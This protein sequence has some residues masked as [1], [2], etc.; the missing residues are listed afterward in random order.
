MGRVL[1][2]DYGQ[3]RVGL[4]VTDP[5]RISANALDTVMVQDLM[6]Y[7]DAYLAKEQ[8]DIFV[9]GKPTQMDG[10]DSDSMQYIQPFMVALKRRFPDKEIVMVDERFSSVMAHRTMR[11]A[12]LGKKARQDKALVDRISATI[13]LQTYLETNG[14][15]LY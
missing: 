13:I 15:I 6:H 4:A 3:K 12:G 1:A 10:S 11:D 14:R 8:V 5:L 9:I 2:I 7:L